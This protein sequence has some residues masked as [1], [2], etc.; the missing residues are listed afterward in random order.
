MFSSFNSM[1]QLQ[2]QKVPETTVVGKTYNGGSS[3]VLELSYRLEGT[4]TLYTFMFINSK[5]SMGDYQ[6]VHF[7]G[8]GNTLN[9]LY[10]ILMTF[11]TDEHKKDKDYTVNLKLGSENVVLKNYRIFGSTSVMFYTPKGYC[12]LTEKQIKKVFNRV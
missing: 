9:D 8:E 4:D 11:F 7:S 3:P 10:N 12:F 1:A 6:S 2:V 5:Y